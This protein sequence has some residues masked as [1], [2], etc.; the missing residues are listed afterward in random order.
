MYVKDQSYGIVPLRRSQG[1]WEVLLVQHLKGHWSMPKGH[2][3]PGETPQ[4]TAK[5]ELFEETGL[6]VLQFFSD[7]SFQE[8]YR[9]KSSNRIID[10]KVDYYVA[11]VVGEVRVQ[12]QELQDALWLSFDQ[13]IQKVSFTE[14]R[15]ILTRSMRLMGISSSVFDK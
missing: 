5:R 11:E 3:D 10:K 14:A 6:T 12:K 7:V 1:Q 13:A 9:F 8:S 15:S 2:P 4:E